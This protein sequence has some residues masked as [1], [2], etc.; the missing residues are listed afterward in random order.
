[1]DANGV[2][3][4]VGRIK[5]VIRTGGKSVQP[6]EVERAL[7][8]H[9]HVE[10]ASV[11]GIADREWGEIVAALVV[12]SA[13]G[14]ITEAALKEHCSNLLSPHKRPKL[15]QFVDALPKSHYGKVQRGKV[16]S[17]I[18]SYRASLAG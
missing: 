13:A 3:S 16:R 15:I 7:C 17:L 18:E 8:E 10:E 2:L 4:I 6:S 12:R 11:V 1:M 9:P 14:E 5:E